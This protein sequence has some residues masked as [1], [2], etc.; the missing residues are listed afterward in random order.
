MTRVIVVDDDALVRITARV[1]LEEAGFDVIETSDGAIALRLLQSAGADLVL[2]DLFMPGIDG[3]EVIREVRRQ[4]PDVKV[5]AMS[6]GG[7]DGTM[8]LLAV[9][10]L[11]GA[12]AAVH[13]P[14]TQRTLLSAIERTL[15]PPAGQNPSSQDASPQV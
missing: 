1:L 14:F 6:G 9:A 3:L 11:L 7:F 13:K 12:S 15:Q 10:R 5:I 4:F 8:D 2:C